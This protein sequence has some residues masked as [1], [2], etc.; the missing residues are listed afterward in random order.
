[1]ETNNTLTKEDFNI[2]QKY[3][4]F[5]I[6]FVLPMDVKMPV[7]EYMVIGHFINTDSNRRC[8]D[9]KLISHPISVFVKYNKHTTLFSQRKENVFLSK[10]D[11]VNGKIKQIED[12]A[13]KIKQNLGL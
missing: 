12:F 4:M 9:Y 1:M 2:E 7:E 6:I 5:D 11:A 3:K 13:K 8:L 10:E